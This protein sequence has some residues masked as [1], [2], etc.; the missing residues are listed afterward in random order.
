MSS[1]APRLRGVAGGDGGAIGMATGRGCGAGTP[2]V[3]YS[4]PINLKT[5]HVVVPPAP[6]AKAQPRQ[7]DMDDEIPF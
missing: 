4:Q 5:G 3:K 2:A 1:T 6:A 7:G